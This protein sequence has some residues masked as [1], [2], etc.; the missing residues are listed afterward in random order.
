MLL[1]PYPDGYAEFVS[2]VD[3]KKYPAVPAFQEMCKSIV[4]ITD[5]NVH[6]TIKR[7]N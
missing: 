3:H 6:I 7:T 2:P 5:Y 1:Y 4:K